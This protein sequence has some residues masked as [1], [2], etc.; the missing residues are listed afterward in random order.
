MNMM[1]AQLYLEFRKRIETI[2]L[3]GVSTDATRVLNLSPLSFRCL[4]LMLNNLVNGK[5]VRFDETFFCA[6]CCNSL[7]GEMVSPMACFPLRNGRDWSEYLS[8]C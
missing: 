3:I 6:F 5:H 7:C 4:F 8:A 2:S 1:D